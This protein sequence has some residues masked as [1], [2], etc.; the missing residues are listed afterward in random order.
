M[1]QGKIIG[2]IIL[3]ILAPV[4]IY[5]LITYPFDYNLDLTPLINFIEESFKTKPHK[6]IEEIIL[7]LLFCIFV[8]LN[9]LFT[10]FYKNKIKVFLKTI[11]TYFFKFTRLT[12]LNKIKNKE[13]T[14]SLFND[15]ENISIVEEE[16]LTI[17]LNGLVGTN[18]QEEK[19]LEVNDEQIKEFINLIINNIKNH[20]DDNKF[21]ENHLFENEKKYKDFLNIF[22]IEKI[23]QSINDIKKETL[24]KNNTFNFIADQFGIYNI[25]KKGRDIR[26]S[27]Y[28]T[29][30]F[31]FRVMNNLFKN[32]ET[33]KKLAEKF[34]KDVNNKNICQEAFNALFP[35]FCSLGVNIILE[36]VSKNKGKCFLIHKRNS[37]VFG[38]DAKYHISV[39]ETFSFTDLS[40]ETPSIDLCILRGIEEEVGIRL[41]KD[42][43]KLTYLDIFLN[44]QRG[45]LGLSVACETDVNP[46][47]IPYYPGIDK[48]TE[49]SKYLFAYNIRN[50]KQMNS[51]LSLFNWIVYTP[52]LLRRYII[53]RQSTINTIY[54][55]Y[56]LHKSLFICIILFYLSCLT[57]I[58]LLFISYLKSRN[59]FTILL[60]AP[61]VNLIWIYISDNCKKNKINRIKRNN[62]TDYISLGEDPFN[63][64]IILYTGNKNLDAK[65]IVIALKN[66][67]SLSKEELSQI[68]KLEYNY[69][70]SNHSN[71]LNDINVKQEIGFDWNKINIL[72]HESGIRHILKNEEYPTIILK[73]HI[74]SPQNITT[75]LYVK[76]FAINKDNNGKTFI[77]YNIINNEKIEF[78]VNHKFEEVFYYEEKCDLSKYAKELLDNKGYTKLFN[79]KVNNDWDS[80]TLLD[81]FKSDDNNSKEKKIFITAIKNSPIGKFKAHTDITN[82]ISLLNQYQYDK[83]ELL[84]LQQLLIRKGE[85]L[86]KKDEI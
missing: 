51:F 62:N 57:I 46:S 52:Y 74:T 85:Y 27:V 17:A 68:I 50:Y 14:Y 71:I 37:N 42:S 63:K 9:I 32:E 58:I 47:Y 77:Y 16:S 49:S 8:A 36:L 39:N 23:K 59:I 19:A 3:E 28:K 60:I 10:G 26:I 69:D 15:F 56:E 43:Y 67:I 76:E 29:T 6:Y 40:N 5:I 38:N 79:L 54:T 86:F 80:V 18:N 53:N 13:N 66:K 22:T 84:M 55:A 35:F 4:L 70:L 81:V 30:Y 41:T 12:L 65:N 78:G 1:K 75:H 25:E 31:T 45:M 72:E 83:M 21:G 44:P 64:N 33:L 48:I 24:K 20:F 7:I 34:C 11:P 73:G 82:C 2:L 61:I